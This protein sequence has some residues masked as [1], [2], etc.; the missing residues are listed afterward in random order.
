MKKLLYL[1][2]LLFV[3]CSF[4]SLKVAF[5]ED[6]QDPKYIEGNDILTEVEKNID[7]IFGSMEE[8]RKI[9]NLYF[10]DDYKLHIKYH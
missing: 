5:A 9:G 10:D 2:C 8:F 1:T 6:Y 4:N 7:D 3:F